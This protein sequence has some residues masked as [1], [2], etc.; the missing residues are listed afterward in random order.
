MV[1]DQTMIQISKL[2]TI[3]IYFTGAETL[4]VG[5]D[6]TRA[7]NEPS[8]AR[9]GSVSERA[10]LSSSISRAGKRGSARLDFGSR[11]IFWYLPLHYLMN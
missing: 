5:R 3:F 6:M 7:G 8:P 10:R 2:A 11:V 1:R 9:C 4:H